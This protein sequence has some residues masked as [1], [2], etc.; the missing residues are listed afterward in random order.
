MACLSL[1]GMSGIGKTHWAKRF[2][3]YGFEHICCDDLIEEKLKPEL[4]KLG[5]KGISDVAKWMGQPYEKQFKK[6]QQKYLDYEIKVMGEI[7]AKLENRKQKKMVI[8]TTGSVIYCGNHILK[9][10]KKL[11]KIVYLGISKSARNEMFRNYL[12]DPKPVIWGKL[13]DQKKSESF[14]QALGRCYPK[15]LEYR[16]NYY[17]KYA[18]FVVPYEK[19]KNG[20]IDLSDFLKT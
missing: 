20:Q 8:D 6:N 12:A 11:T 15:L 3:D 17:K 5:Y 10:L 2:K 18:H 4:R 7:L 19:H 9:K 1:I 16:Q 13:F 14:H